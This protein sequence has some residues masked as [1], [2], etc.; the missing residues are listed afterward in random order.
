MVPWLDLIGNVS[1][2]S[3]LRGEARDVAIRARAIAL[4]ERVGLGRYRDA[5]PNACF[6]GMRQRAAIARTLIE[7]RPVVLMDEPFFSLDAITRVRLQDLAAELLAGRTVLLVT[8]DPM[9]AL[10]LGHRI[11]VMSG[12]PARLDMA[13]APIGDPPRNPQDHAVISAYGDLLARLV[14]AGGAA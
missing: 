14:A 8:H 3:R 11:H 7:D 1:I 12:K 9:E 10:R 13:L 2:G 5:L 4:L 6:G